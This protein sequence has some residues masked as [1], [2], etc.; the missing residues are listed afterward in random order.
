MKERKHWQFS[1]RTLLTGIILLNIGWGIQYRIHKNEISE[2]RERHKR[3]IQGIRED[4]APSYISIREIKSY[5]LNQRISLWPPRRR[6]EVTLH[7]RNGD[8]AEFGDD[9]IME[10][11]RHPTFGIVWKDLRIS[12]LG[13]SPYDPILDPNSADSALYI[14]LENSRLEETASE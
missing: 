8:T 14:P 13:L 7:Y 9:S 12:G 6:K 10:V 3:E 5:S 11:Y 4:Q 1:L 2:L